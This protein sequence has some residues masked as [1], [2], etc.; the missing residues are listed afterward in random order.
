[1]KATWNG[2][3][4]AESDET[5]VIAGNHYFPPEAIRREHFALSE[6]HTTCHW[7]GEASYFDVVAGGER[8]KDAAWLY[9]APTPAAKDTAGN[10]LVLARRRRHEVR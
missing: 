8:N 7:K 9:P 1:M 6:T 2:A 10:A 4:L 3:V 5:I